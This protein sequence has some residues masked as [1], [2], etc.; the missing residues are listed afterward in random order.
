M[1]RP[2]ITIGYC[3]RCTV[4]D[5]GQQVLHVNTRPLRRRPDFMCLA[6]PCA[7]TLTYSPTLHRK[8]L[9]RFY[10]MP[11]QP[12]AQPIGHPA[13]TVAAAPEH[14]PSLPTAFLTNFT[15]DPVNSFTVN[16]GIV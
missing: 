16:G 5:R 1:A 3:I 7:H 13:A 11:V 14:R 9:Q 12:I 2:T 10:T 4:T 6:E 15:F 8:D